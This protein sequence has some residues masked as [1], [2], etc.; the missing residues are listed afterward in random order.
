MGLELVKFDLYDAVLA[1]TVATVMPIT[2]LFTIGLNESI[3]PIGA[4]ANINKTLAHTNFDS[5]NRQLPPPQSFLVTSLRQAIKGGS[6]IAGICF[7]DANNIQYS[8]IGNFWAGST[9]RSYFQGLMG[10]IP[11]AQNQLF[12]GA[13]G[14][15]VGVGTWLGFGYPMVHNQYSLQTGLI[16][17]S[18]G[19]P[20]QGVVIN[21][22]RTFYFS[23][24]PTLNI[25]DAQ[26]PWKTG[27][28]GGATAGVGF[29]DY[30]F[31]CGIMARAIAG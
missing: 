2:N 24:D 22:G 23:W 20:D 31:L 18:T 3:L 29:F 15:P 28:A 17:P 13:F 25:T 5:T 27:A 16:D 14:T 4:G 19:Q 26:T 12:G 30:V 10:D 9:K 6:G 7:V 21:Q 11:C 8:T 1:P